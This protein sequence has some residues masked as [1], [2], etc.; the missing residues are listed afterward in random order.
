MGFASLVSWAAF[1][2]SVYF[3]T[4]SAFSYE[5]AAVAKA[6]G[7]NAVSFVH[8]AIILVVA[9][10]AIAGRSLD[11]ASPNS[12][13]VAVVLAFSRAFFSVHNVVYAFSAWRTD[14]MVLI[15]NLSSLALIGAATKT[16]GAP[17]LAFLYVNAMSD[18]VG[19][20]ARFVKHM[21]SSYRLVDSS[22][23]AHA[24][25][26][27]ATRAVFLP[28]LAV[29]FFAAGVAASGASVRDRVF[30]AIAP[31]AATISVPFVA[32]DLFDEARIF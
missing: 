8:D 19:A 25:V 1:H 22:N 32:C 4:K 24:V 26:F 27:V 10:W 28:L 5:P 21:G 29:N 2:A 31:V 11:F 7:A 14:P 20:F 15:G 3:G 17:V 16:A 23:V 9:P 12:A 13:A 18:A 6:V 30:W